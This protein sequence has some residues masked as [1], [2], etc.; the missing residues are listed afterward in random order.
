[1]DV[2]ICTVKVTEGFVKPTLAS[3]KDKPIMSSAAYFCT[4]Y[5]KAKFKRHIE[6]RCGRNPPI[7]FNTRKI[8]EGITACANKL[9]D[10]VKTSRATRNFKGGSWYQAEP[11]QACN[12]GKKKRLKLLIVRNIEES[13]VLGIPGFS[14]YPST[15]S[16]FSFWLWQ[17][18][19]L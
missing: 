9:K 1:M 11:T 5:N 15:T 19:L 3:F 4:C 16:S 14:G 17:C 12:K 13:G 7:Q 18:G 6:A 10:A 8:V 2:G